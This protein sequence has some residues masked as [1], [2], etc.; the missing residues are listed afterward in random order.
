MSSNEK[1]VLEQPIRF[2]CSSTLSVV[3]FCSMG[4]CYKSASG[5][6]SIDFHSPCKAVHSADI[7]AAAE[8]P[9]EP[10]FAGTPPA[11]D[12]KIYTNKI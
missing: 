3:I 1:K 11:N 12:I 9:A 6:D 2:G 5:K 10:A 8:N 7:T 4:Q